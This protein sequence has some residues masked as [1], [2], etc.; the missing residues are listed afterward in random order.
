MTN[1]AL[2]F[3]LSSVFDSQVMATLLGIGYFLGVFFLS[4]ILW[5]VEGMHWLLQYFVWWSP[6][7]YATEAMRSIMLRG[8]G[9]TYPVVYLGFITTIVWIGIYLALTLLSLKL[10]K[11]VH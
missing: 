2:G 4:G 9:I 8:W 6:L 7:T 11:A 3:F 10:K 1:S 5:P